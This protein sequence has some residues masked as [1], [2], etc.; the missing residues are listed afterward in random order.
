MT[1]ARAAELRTRAERVIAGQQSGV[2]KKADLAHDLIEA[3][4]LL[5][6]AERALLVYNEWRAIADRHPGFLCRDSRTMAEQAV[7]RG[8]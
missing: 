3:I 6:A 7:A 8:T 5:A 1:A 2:Y 4:D